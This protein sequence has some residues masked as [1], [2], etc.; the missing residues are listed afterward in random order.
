MISSFG[1]RNFKC[2]KSETLIFA[3]FTLLSGLNGMGKSTILQA[4]LLLRQ[5]YQHGVL[6][7]NGLLLNGYFVE[8]GTATDALYEGGEDYI[9]FL[10]ETGAGI[11]AMWRFSH[12]KGRDVQPLDVISV[13][14]KIYE[15]ELFTNSFHYL[16]AERVGPRTSFKMADH[17]HLR[18]TQTGKNGEY[19]A[20]L[21]AKQERNTISVPG[22]S[23]PDTH[24]LELREQVEAWI[25]EICPGTRIHL[26]EY[27]GMDVV[28]LEFSFVRRG[29]PGRKFRATNVGFGLTYVLPIFISALASR[30]G[31]LILVEN[32]E[33]HLH[34]RGQAIIGRFLALAAAQGVQ[35]IVETHSDHVLNGLRVA[36]REGKL[37]PDSV[38]L[39]F[40]TLDEKSTENTIISPKID[41]NGRIDQW[42][43]DFFD[44][45]E[46]GLAQLL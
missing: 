21:L 3:P 29:L 43:E 37:D 9:E 45:W 28:N 36:V 5:S 12:V 30:P 1:V 32:P 7:E 17:D 26:T 38:A 4:L 13:P 31:S 19:C 44:E 10:L 33:A 20:H 40:F 16:Q 25:S 24:T 39:H 22:L 23:H 46:K 15:E 27:P 42:P 41:N 11:K 2:F 34:P 35:V 8:I 18:Y 6:R 14:E